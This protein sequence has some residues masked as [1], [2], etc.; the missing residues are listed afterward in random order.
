MALAW[1]KVVI[2][3]TGV[4]ILSGGGIAYQKLRRPPAPIVPSAVDALSDLLDLSDA[5]VRRG[6]DLADLYAAAAAESIAWI[7]VRMD[8]LDPDVLHRLA[9]AQLVLHKFDEVLFLQNYVLKLHPQNA[10]AWGIQGDA[11]RELGKYRSADSSYYSMYTFDQGFHSML[12]VSREEFLLRD[13]DKALN[14]IDEAIEKGKGEDLEPRE[15]ATGYLQLSEMLLARGHLEPALNNIEYAL[16]LR[17]EWAAALA[18]KVRLLR[19]QRRY[20]EAVDVCR[21]LVDISHHPRYKATLARLYKDLDRPGASD[22]LVQVAAAQFETLA[23]DFPERTRRDRVEFYLEWNLEPEKALRLAS[24][25]S[26]KRRDPDAYSLLAWAYYRNGNYDLAWSS[27]ALAL[28]R[29]VQ[30]PKFFYRAALIA[31][32]AGKMDKYR[33]FAKRIRDITPNVEL[34]Y[35]PL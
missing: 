33:T 11:F 10:M 3:L 25:E 32:A 17:P 23:R 31:K 2:V 4:I 29:D 19:I 20:G 35:G 16:A 8:S 28:R 6:E 15:L 7:A 13:Y 14:F 21:R 30:H 1:K 12:R 27:I 18:V 22:S 26:R 24:R 34:V 9:R 5:Y